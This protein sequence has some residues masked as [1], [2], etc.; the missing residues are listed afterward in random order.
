[1]FK[2][3]AACVLL[4]TGPAPKATAPADDDSIIP[5]AN[6]SGW[7]VMIDME[8]GHTCFIMGEYGSGSALR[9]G[10][11]RQV[12]DRP[13]YIVVT[14]PSWKEYRHGLSYPMRLRFE[15]APDR[16]VSGK[17]TVAGGTTALLFRFA[18]KEFIS[19]FAARSSL[20]LIDG[21][22]EIARLDLGSSRQA[23]AAMLTCQVQVD[24]LMGDAEA[25]DA[26]AVIG[27]DDV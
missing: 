23:V 9:I 7:D 5:Y 1:M 19:D 17:A 14:S 11:N 16:A 10:V 24:A 27:K 26:T 6:V 2:M 8:L 4:A 18:D 13:G 3:M 21:S 20:K 25:G 22:R 12:R 15:G